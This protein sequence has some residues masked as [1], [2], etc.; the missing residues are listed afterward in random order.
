[1][2]TKTSK[3]PFRIV[4]EDAS[5]LIEQA[6]AQIDW[7]VQHRIACEGLTILGAKPKAGKSTLATQLMVDIAEGRP[8]LGFSTKPVDILH[9][10]L[11]GP[12]TYPGMRFKK[13]GHTGARGKIHVFRQT[14]PPTREEG[15]DA[16]ITFLRE[17]PSVKL[18]VID[19]LPKLLRLWDSDKYDA[20]V[21]AMERLEK[22]A[23]AFHVQIVCVAHSKKRSGEEAGD[24]LMGSTAHRASSDTNILLTRQGNQRIIQTEQRLGDDL[25]PHQLNLNQE[26]Q[27]LSLGK[28]IEEVEEGLRGA[29]K[30]ETRGRVESEIRETLLKVPGLTTRELVKQVLGKAETIISVLD[31]MEGGKKLHV[32]ERGFTKYYSVA[33][34]ETEPERI[35]A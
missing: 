9:L 14:M 12:K 31:E 23:Q 22:I 18:I 6:P 13:L 24:S 8:F 26:T 3:E 19:T 27:V 25:A 20:T 2:T 17:H 16:L 34:I 32:V 5:M 7:L 15:T 1:M 4:T 21:L 30:K 11:E 28:P 35:A 10:H 33:E 29:R